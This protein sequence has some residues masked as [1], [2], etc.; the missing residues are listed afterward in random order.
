M[1]PSARWEKVLNFPC[2]TLQHP[3]PAPCMH[4][5]SW[6]ACLLPPSFIPVS[7]P[8]SPAIT[9]GYTRKEPHT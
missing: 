3:V 8:L 4:S 6:A 1:F 5:V 7:D 2:L 9:C